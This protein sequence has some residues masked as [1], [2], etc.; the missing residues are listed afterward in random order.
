MPLIYYAPHVAL[1]L[2]TELPIHIRLPNEALDTNYGWLWL[3]SWLEWLFFPEFYFFRNHHI[4][5]GGVPNIVVILLWFALFMKIRNIVLT[6]RNNKA[7]ILNFFALMI[8]N[9]LAVT[10]CHT[11]Y[12]KVFYPWTP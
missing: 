3:S 10:F 7:N 11:A 4:L 5:F 6:L 8:F 12:I 9:E 2:L 1:H